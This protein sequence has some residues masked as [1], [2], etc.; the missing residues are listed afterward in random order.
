MPDL[1]AFLS[2]GPGPV[3]AR[4]EVLKHVLRE[5]PPS[6]P[7]F[8]GVDDPVLR[9]ISIPTVR[10]QISNKS[11]NLLHSIYVP[12]LKHPDT[13]LHAWKAAENGYPAEKGQTLAKAGPEAS[14]L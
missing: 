8:R 10:N 13:F 12:A 1:L 6:W 9:V 3:L 2:P 5:Q 14:W 7:C 11:V 4:E